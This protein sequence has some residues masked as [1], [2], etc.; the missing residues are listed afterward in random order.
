[1]LRAISASLRANGLKWQQA[2]ALQSQ[3]QAA[4]EMSAQAAAPEKEPSAGDSFKAG[5]MD[6]KHRVV[7]VA[8]NRHRRDPSTEAP[9]EINAV[10]YED[11]A[12]D[13]GLLV[14]ECL[15]ISPYARFMNRTS[16][17]ITE[18]Q[19]DGWKMVMDRVRA[20]GGYMFAQLAHPGRATHSTF[21]VD[22]R[23]PVAPSPKPMS[24]GMTK[25]EDKDAVIHFE[26][27]KVADAADMKEV[28]DY[29]VKGAKIAVEQCGFDGVEIHA[30]Y[31]YLLHQF[32]SLQ[33]NW[34]TDKYGGSPENRAR[35]VFEV[36]D[37]VVDAVGKDRVGI[38]FMPGL[39]FTD[40][41]DAEPDI[42]D[43]LR[44][45]GPELEKRQLAYVCL[46]S[47]NGEPY[48]RV[49]G[50]KKPNVSVDI[51]K[52]FRLFYKGNLLI[53]G[54][55]T[56]EDGRKYISEGFSDMVGYGTAYISNA[57][58]HEL[59]LAGWTHDKLNPGYRQPE[60]YFSQDPKGYN[61]W[62]LVKP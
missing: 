37:A 58:L 12:S 15:A 47:F 43:M 1:M 35:F 19:I 30:G 29:F 14:A 18:P 59:L 11:R 41:V 20:K 9:G 31:G 16:A 36:L 46:T 44:Y 53:N 28:I 52:F 27:P 48:F 55:L 17:L 54:S 3:S 56:L 45:L 38:K 33:T 26:I 8:M 24:G 6:L 4:R 60:L 32:L 42:M 61:D 49:L 2:L 13:G 57:N 34:R 51:F 39:T 25:L 21:N 40:L 22:G 7:M 10:W 5:V 23:I 50:L 62:P